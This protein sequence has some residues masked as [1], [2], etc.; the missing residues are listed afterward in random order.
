LLTGFGDTG[1]RP[2]AIAPAGEAAVLGGPDKYFNPLVFGLPAPGYLGTLGRGTLRG[3]GLFTLD[4]AV[5]KAFRVTEN[6]TVR[7][8]GEF[9]NVTNEAN[10]QIPSGQEL[11]TEQGGRI[12]SA[13]RITTTASPA[14]QIQVAIRYEF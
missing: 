14:R 9:F 5:H 7:L 12:G 13:G 8:R 11:F 4:L 10:F 6:Q 2:D 1:Q 3:P